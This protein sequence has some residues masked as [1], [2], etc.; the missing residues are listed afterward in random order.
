MFHRACVM[1]YLHGSLLTLASDAFQAAAEHPDAVAQKRAVGG[2]VNLAFDDRRVRS[3]FSSLGYALLAGQ[4]D[5]P[6]MNLFGDRR[7]QQGKGAAEGREIGSSP[8][9]EVSEA[10]VD[11]VA[12]QLP[13]Q[14]AEAPALQMLHDTAAQQTIRG[15]SGAPSTFRKRA[16]CGQTL[17]DQVD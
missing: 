11:Q 5:H 12:A 1:H 2:V 17:A 9:I 13:F 3:N 16:A 6:L 7:A 15:D 14:I 8:G 4:A 10:A